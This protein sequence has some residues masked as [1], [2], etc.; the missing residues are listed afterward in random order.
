M[1]ILFIRRK[2]KGGDVLFLSGLRKILSILVLT[3]VLFGYSGENVK[4]EGFGVTTELSD[5]SIL[6]IDY[7]TLDGQILER[8]V[9]VGLPFGVYQESPK[10]FEGYFSVTDSPKSIS[11]T[12]EKSSVYVTFWYRPDITVTIE[13]KTGEY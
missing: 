3:L 4:A 10:H 1:R 5:Y 13:E 11:I 6:V 2:I 9:T 7:K 12:K 8:D